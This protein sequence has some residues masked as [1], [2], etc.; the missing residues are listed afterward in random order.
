MTIKEVKAMRR[1]DVDLARVRRLVRAN[2]YTARGGHRQPA[3]GAWRRQQ[4]GIN[5]EYHVGEAALYV[6]GQLLIQVVPRLIWAVAAGL[7]LAVVLV[8]KAFFA[9]LMD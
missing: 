6:S 8:V 4:V 5:S 1:T 3:S 2:H 7:V 9:A